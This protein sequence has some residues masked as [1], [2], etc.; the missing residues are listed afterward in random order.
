MRN[1][2]SL[3]SLFV[4]CGA[5]LLAI[6][7]VGV[8]SAQDDLETCSVQVAA[9]LSTI[10]DL[11]PA[12]SPGSACLV[13]GA[14]QINESALTEPGTRFSL[15]TPLI[16]QTR[17]GLTLISYFSNG[18]ENAPRPPLILLFGEI[19]ITSELVELRELA[20]LPDLQ[21]AFGDPVGCTDGF[22]PFAV[23]ASPDRSPVS[24]VINGRTLTFDGIIVLRRNGDVF[25]VLAATGS[26]ALNDQA[27]PTGSLLEFPVDAADNA[28]LAPTPL[29]VTDQALVA[30]LLGSSVLQLSDGSPLPT[31]TLAATPTVFSG[32]CVVRSEWS[33]YIVAAGDTLQRIALRSGSSVRELQNANCLTNPDLIY[34]G[35]R[36]YVP[37]LPFPPVATPV[38]TLV[39]PSETP[40]PNPT[41]TTEPTL[42]PTAETTD[43]AAPA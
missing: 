39:L 16:V 20:T 19:S 22:P 4:I 36:L 41:A 25:Q 21:V 40:S 29:S 7:F 18:E 34:V 9:A 38:A 42:E 30:L 23:L 17:S 12:R 35:Q 31:S 28:A 37:R 32:V 10:A 26:V 13:S 1:R 8:A 33:A 43:E 3:F 6:S 27:V 24:F 14:S 5:L 11:C 15:T 2:S